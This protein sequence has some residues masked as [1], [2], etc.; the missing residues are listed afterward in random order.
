M[1]ILTYIFCV[2]R[3]NDMEWPSLLLLLLLCD[4][5]E[6]LCILM[7]FWNTSSVHSQLYVF[8]VQFL[9]N[10]QSIHLLYLAFFF[11]RFF[12][13]FM[14]TSININRF[15]KMPL[16]KMHLKKKKEKTK[17]KEKRNIKIKTK[18]IA[19]LRRRHQNGT[20]TELKQALWRE[21]SVG[22][23]NMTE[24]VCLFFFF[25][26]S[27]PLNFRRHFCQFWNRRDEWIW[28]SMILANFYFQRIFSLFV[29]VCVF[30]TT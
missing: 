30:V 20:Q 8:A 18:F 7:C 15:G 10:A 22:A 2:R 23:V 12:H 26:F 4:C 17:P 27:W 9:H 19:F 29:C 13:L 28:V 21:T 25:S 5:S 14:H 16:R 1:W 11:F 6:L 24:I 3:P